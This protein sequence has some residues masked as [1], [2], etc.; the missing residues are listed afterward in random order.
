MYCFRQAV[1]AAIK[2]NIKLDKISVYV[3]QDCAV[4]IDDVLEECKD[5][6]TGEWKSVVILIP[7]RLG[8]EKF[9]PV[10]GPC[11]TALFS[12]EQCIGVIG[13]RPK[14]SLYFVGYQDDK[15]IHLDPHYC[16]E[17][18]DVDA[19]NFPFS[20]FH[21]RSP[22]KMNLSKMDPSCCIGFY[23]AEKSDFFTLKER[24]EASVLPS[25]S[26]L[27]A[28]YPMFVFAE[29]HG[30]DA[31]EIP[32]YYRQTDVEYFLDDPDVNLESEEFAML[33]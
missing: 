33:H 19:H 13:G 30:T 18:V 10:Y 21:C 31:H 27:N 12:L 5:E 3:A 28:D 16:Q 7:V 23:C 24:Y 14:H 6:K 9:N 17:M 1:K 25:N 26:S 32:E 11:L 29:G 15:L 8:N 4:Y 20:T 2:D 22:R